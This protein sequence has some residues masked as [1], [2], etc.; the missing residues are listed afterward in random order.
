MRLP[1]IKTGKQIPASR[2]ASPQERQKRLDCRE[3]ILKLFLVFLSRN[4]RDGKDIC[5]VPRV[6]S[7]FLPEDASVR[8]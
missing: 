8:A 4:D 3:R 2:M 7:K 6:P 1:F 5:F